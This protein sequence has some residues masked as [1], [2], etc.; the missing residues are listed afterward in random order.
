MVG[1]SQEMNSNPTEDW[2]RDSSETVEYFSALVEKHGLASAAV[3]WGSPVSQEKRFS[4]LAEIG[5]LDHT[6]V[7]DV[8]C[9][10][11][12]FLPWL[13]QRFPAI[14]YTGID[15]TPAMIAKARERFPSADFRVCDFL[16]FEEQTEI[17]DY[18][19]SSGLFYLRKSDPYAFVGG[20][21]RK[22]F[23]CCRRGVAFNSLSSWASQPA[24]NEF[25]ADPVEIIRIARTLTDIIVFRHDYHAGD[26]TIYLR[27]SRP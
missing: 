2:K 11:G 26:F 22:M 20:M 19:F 15:V 1:N 17:Y 3:D 14:T 23:S 13:R 25:Y 5:S 7:L 9:G 4:V 16:D 6:S 27:K 10:L 21:L 24:V 8:G 18:V 12:D